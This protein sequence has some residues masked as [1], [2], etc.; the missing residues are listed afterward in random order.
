LKTLHL[1]IF[2]DEDHPTDVLEAWT[3]TVDT[4]IKG[5]NGAQLA[6]G[7]NTTDQQGTSTKVTLNRAKYSLI[8]FVRQLTNMSSAMP[9]LFA[10]KFISL[11]I[12]YTEDTPEGYH[13]PGF[14]HP[15]YDLVS[16]PSDEDWERVTTSI[17]ILHTGYDAD[18]LKV[19]HLRALNPDIEHALPQGLKCTMQTGKM[20]D[21]LLDLRQRATTL[22]VPHPNSKAFKRIDLSPVE[23]DAAFDVHTQ[24]AK[25][26]GS[27][28]TRISTRDQLEQQQL[29]DMVSS[30]FPL[31]DNYADSD[32]ALAAQ[33]GLKSSSNSGHGYYRPRIVE[34]RNQNQHQAGRQPG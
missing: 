19:S 8:E 25:E 9:S 5:A 15:V 7:F 30:V 14:R 33:M 20:D 6:S 34:A 27:R 31:T 26:C 10:K 24:Q 18:G 11:E 28:P 32:L 23:D 16:F 12:G 21:V 13:A 3:L 1:S 22:S 17:G 29:R 4:Y 2:E